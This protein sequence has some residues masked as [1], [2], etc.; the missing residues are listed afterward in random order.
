MHIAYVDDSGDEHAYGLGVLIVPAAN[1]SQV[2]DAMVG[3]RRHLSHTHGIKMAKELK[4]SQL[5]SGGGSWHKAEKRTRHGIA[6]AAM[7]LLASLDAGVRTFGVVAKNRRHLRLV[8]SAPHA[9]WTLV[10]ERLNTFS[11]KEQTKILVIQDDGSPLVARSVARRM[12]RFNWAP[13]AY[14]S[15]ARSFKFDSLLDD[16]IPAASKDSY[17][18]QWCDLVAYSAFRAVCPKAW[19]PDTWSPLGASV[20][21]EVNGLKK[22]KGWNEEPP[23]ILLAPR[24]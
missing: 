1:W 4:A 3:F 9:A 14:G 19:I 15:K 16:P 7:S 6:I 12:R 17:M 18:L 24:Y 21:R 22:G 5:M 11:R 2:F 23:G 13:S 20:L 10:L 8:P